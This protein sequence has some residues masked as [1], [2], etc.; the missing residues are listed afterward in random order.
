MKQIKLTPQ[1]GTDEKTLKKF[2]DW[3]VA[4]RTKN[5]LPFNVVMIDTAANEQY[6]VLI[7]CQTLHDRD[8]VV[9]ALRELQEGTY[10]PT[11]N[12]WRPDDG[13]GVYVRELQNQP[14]GRVFE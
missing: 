3:L 8:A 14:I 7:H 2:F 1:A 6:G 13:D 9:A 12:D 10:K 5:E 11:K 4:K